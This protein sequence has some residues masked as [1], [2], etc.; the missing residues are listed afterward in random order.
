MGARL[1]FLPIRDMLS[2]S[3]ETDMGANWFEVDRIGLSKQLA[4]KGWRWIVYEL[5]QNAWDEK[6]TRVDVALEPIPDRPLAKISVKDDSPDGFKNLSH[7]FT[8]FAET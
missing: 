7:A 6:S 3:E 2:V 4:R 8:L 5:V 1:E